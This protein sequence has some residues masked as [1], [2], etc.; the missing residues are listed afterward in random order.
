[1]NIKELEELT[2]S[3]IKNYP[4]FKE[5]FLDLYQYAL[6]EIEEGGSETHE[7]ELSYNSMM[8]IVE[9][10]PDDPSDDLRKEEEYNWKQEQIQKE[11]DENRN[12]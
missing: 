2:D 8:E 4:E 12:L 3:L 10:D 11:I 6:D 5:D 7:C 9:Y 1:M